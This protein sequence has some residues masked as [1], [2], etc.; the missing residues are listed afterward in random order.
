MRV[1]LKLHNG[2]VSLFAVYVPINEPKNKGKAQKFNLSLQE[3]V[4][5]VP[6]KDVM[7]VSGDFNAWVGNDANT[8]H[9]PLGRFGPSEQNEKGQRLLEYCALNDH[10]I[11]NTFFQHKPRHQ[12][13]WFHLTETTRAEYLLDYAL[14]TK[15]S[16]AVCWIPECSTRPSSNQI[17]GN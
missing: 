3:V 8:S 11:T 4:R 17:I 14:S 12:Y 16:G 9:D 1:S 6:P 5:R 7:L 10:V 2:Y 13:T 15:G